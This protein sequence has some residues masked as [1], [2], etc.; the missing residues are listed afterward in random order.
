MGAAV[1]AGFGRRGGRQEDDRRGGAQ[2]V[3]NGVVASLVGAWICL[4]RGQG[5]R[6]GRVEDL[7]GIPLSRVVKS[8]WGYGHGDGRWWVKQLR[9]NVSGRCV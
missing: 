1:A 7:A 6:A 5:P 8:L 9:Q 2:V 3:P 4:Q